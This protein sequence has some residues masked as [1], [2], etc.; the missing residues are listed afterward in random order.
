M[1]IKSKLKIPFQITLN[2]YSAYEKSPNKSIPKLLMQTYFDK[3]RIPGYILDNVKKYAGDYQYSL[4]DDNDIRSFLNK[5]F[6][7]E[8]SDFFNNI[9][10][11]AYK[12][13]FFRYCYIYINGGIYMDIKTMQIRNLNEIIDHSVI[14]DKHQLYSVYSIIKNNIYQGFIASTPKNPIFIDLI[15]EMM[16][17]YDINKYHNTDYLILTRQFYKVLQNYKDSEIIKLFQEK[18][19][20]NYKDKSKLDRYGGYCTVLNDKELLFETRDP[21]YPY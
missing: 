20:N 16:S 11:G 5:Y 21:K 17:L 19:D 3:S 15:K 1:S 13:D 9:T 14:S 12:A 7:K 2:D 6:I 8:V 4:F 10:F 18:C